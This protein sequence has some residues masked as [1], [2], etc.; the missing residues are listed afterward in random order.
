MNFDFTREAI[1]SILLDPHSRRE[2][3]VQGF[4]MLRTYIGQ[5]RRFRLNVWHSE[6]AVPNVSLIH[7][8]PWDFESLILA[9]QLGNRRYVERGACECPRHALSSPTHQ[10]KRIQPGEN[11][12]G[13]HVEEGVATLLPAYASE[14]YFPRHVYK[15]QA[16]EIHATSYLDGTV[17]LNDR[18]PVGEDLA[19]VFWPYG[20][21]WVDAKPRPATREE[22]DFAT[23][24][25]LRML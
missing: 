10:W 11:Y 6:L 13:T 8:H 12:D 22:I 9:G 18:T 17:T 1:R 24:R 3:S 2:W 5:G 25:A 15:Q 14:T 4:G 16:K 23:N 7:D 20:E 21:E 19:R